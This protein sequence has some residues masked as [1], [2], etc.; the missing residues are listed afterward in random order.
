MHA[1]TM[2]TNYDRLNE[3]GVTVATLEATNVS[4]STMKCVRLQQTPT[5]LYSMMWALVHTSLSH[6]TLATMA[7]WNHAPYTTQR[8]C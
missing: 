1:T 8:L 5:I 2:A 7:H 4:L 3:M 6:V